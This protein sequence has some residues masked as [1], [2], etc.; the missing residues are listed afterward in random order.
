MFVDRSLYPDLH[1]RLMGSII[2]WNPSFIQVLCQTFQY[3]YCNSADKLTNP[4]TNWHGWK[5]YLL[6]GGSK[7]SN[8]FTDL[9]KWD[10][11]VFFLWFMDCDVE[12]EVTYIQVTSA[13]TG[14]PVQ[15]VI[16]LNKSGGSKDEKCQERKN[17][18]LLD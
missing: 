10:I 4:L 18:V 16:E 9:L 7:I 2:G 13:K 15:T 1:Q 8:L 11:H 12:K 3:L 6:G 5:H 14:Y 17:V